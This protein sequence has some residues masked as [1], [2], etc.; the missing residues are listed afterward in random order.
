MGALTS[1]HRVGNE[2][3]PVHTTARTNQSAAMETQMQRHL[4][5]HCGDAQVSFGAGQAPMLDLQEG[6]YICIRI[7]YIYTCI[8]LMYQC[9]QAFVEVSYMHAFIKV[10]VYS[11]MHT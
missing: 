7:V 10:I 2:G 6:Q 4:D 9:M 5:T 1:F 8:C 3:I 11:Q